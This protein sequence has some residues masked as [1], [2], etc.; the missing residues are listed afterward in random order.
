MTLTWCF[1]VF[2]PWTRFAESN[3]SFAGA[4]PCVS[5]LDFKPG[6]M[7]QG[8]RTLGDAS[9]LQRWVGVPTAFVRVLLI[10][11][12]FSLTFP[13]FKAIM[14]LLM[15]FGCLDST[16][17]ICSLWEGFITARSSILTM[18]TSGPCSSSHG[19][20][21]SGPSS[22]SM[23][24]KSVSV[25]LFSLFNTVAEMFLSPERKLSLSLAE[26]LLFWLSAIHLLDSWAIEIGFSGEQAAGGK[27]GRYWSTKC[28]RNGCFKSSDAWKISLNLKC[29]D[30]NELLKLKSIVLDNAY[31]W[32]MLGVLSQHTFDKCFPVYKKINKLTA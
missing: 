23:E 18:Q 28:C 16:V 19:G 4:R 3:I 14:I 9:V 5:A 26:L 24:I 17:D 25:A 1:K 7:E 10:G 13:S 12:P 2:D 6:A 11:E 22:S 31:T 20:G 27:V 21:C 29:Q 30:D 8:L 32:P 15:V